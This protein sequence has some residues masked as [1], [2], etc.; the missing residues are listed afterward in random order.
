M[1]IGASSPTI[2]HASRA[3]RASRPTCRW[4]PSSAAT[5]CRCRKRTRIMTMTF[6]PDLPVMLAFAVATFVLMITPGP[7]MAL[8]MS[9]A[10]NYGRA[11]GLAAMFGAMTGI[12]VHTTLVAFGI[13]VL[14]LAAPPLFMA[15]KIAGALYL[16]WL[17]WQAIAH[18]GG[19]RLTEAAK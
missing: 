4:K 2:W 3:C 5:N 17:A 9:R 8:Q 1:P 12:M 11:H 14:I 15:L 10:I 6:V 7:D 18:G 13:S 16:L 19:L